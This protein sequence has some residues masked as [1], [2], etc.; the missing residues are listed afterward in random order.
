[1]RAAWFRWARRGNAAR[2]VRLHIAGAP[3]ARRRR[4]RCAPE[5]ALGCARDARHRMRARPEVRRSRGAPAAFHPAQAVRRPQACRAATRESAARSGARSRNFDRAG[6]RG[7]VRVRAQCRRDAIGSPSLPWKPLAR[8]TIDRATVVAR[9][10][11]G[12]TQSRMA[13]HRAARHREG[14]PPVPIFRRTQLARA[15]NR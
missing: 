15:G 14:A 9:S 6:R 11:S 1:M 4:R 13:P 7:S 8:L 10:R 12:P 3:A 5:V 2:C